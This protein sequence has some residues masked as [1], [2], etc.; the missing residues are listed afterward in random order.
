MIGK[1]PRPGKGFKGLVSYLLH[2]DRRKPHDKDRVAWVETRNLLVRD[3]AKAPSLMRATAALSKRVKRP[4]YHYVISWH[5][6]EAPSD[7]IM[8]QVADTTCADLGLDD[9]QALYIAHKDTEHRHVH[10]VVNR[11]HPETRRAWKTSHD[12]RR[13]EQSLRRQAE[14]MGLDYVPGRHNDP[15]RFYAKGSRRRM[16][17]RA[18][19][20]ARRTG[21]R[22]AKAA[23]LRKEQIAAF[24]AV[25]HGATSWEQLDGALGAMGLRLEAKGQGAVVFDGDIEHKLS[26]FGKEARLKHLQERFGERL[27]EHRAKPAAES[28]RP[29][30]DELRGAQGRAQLAKLLQEAK[31]LDKVA[32]ARQWDH[33]AAL[34]DA[35]EWPFAPVSAYEK[36]HQA[37]LS[38]ADAAAA[39]D[40]AYCLH[41][42]GLVDRKQLARATRERDEAQAALE[43][44]QSTVDRLI[45]DAT[46][47]LFGTAKERREAQKRIAKHAEKERGP[48]FDRS[49]DKDRDY[50]L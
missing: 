47:A 50:D 14:D 34:N 13:I 49:D 48:V 32:S 23:S 36:R 33:H 41:A 31:M 40:F 12:Y 15:E 22:P 45:T 4:V 18:Y 7:D 35:I 5:R 20:Y 1:V 16:K 28:E 26:A 42:I 30:E 9:Y 38:Y 10:I 39:A 8:R 27:A 17:D 2:G 21:K 19:Q 29:F 6:D 25:Y 37:Y 24:L 43:N 11:V 46:K 3:P 44:Y